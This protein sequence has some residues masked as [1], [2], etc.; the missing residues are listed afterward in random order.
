MGSASGSGLDEAFGKYD[1]DGSGM[2]TA[3]EF[4][5]ACEDIGFGELAN[6]LFME[7]DP[8]N[9][10]NISPATVLG[11][12]K[13]SR[14]I[15]RNAKR[16]I[17][18]LAF[19]GN[20]PDA[21]VDTSTWRLTGESKELLRAEMLKQMRDADPPARV[22][23]VFRAMLGYG[24]DAAEA[25]QM[26][27]EDFDAAMARIGLPPGNAW[28]VDAVFKQIDVNDDGSIGVPELR[29]W[30]NGVEM[31]KALAKS[32][33]L[34]S[35]PGGRE[36]QL[37]ELEWSPAVMREQI[38]LTLIANNLA[39]IDLLRAY[40]TAGDDTFAKRNMLGMCKEFVDDMVLWDDCHV[41]DVVVE[42]YG[43]LMESAKTAYSLLMATD[44]FDAARDK[45]RNDEK[46]R[47]RAQATADKIAANRGIPI[48]ELQKFLQS[49]WSDLKQEQ[50]G[51]GIACRRK[52]PPPVARPPPMLGD[53][54]WPNRVW[55][56][57][58]SSTAYAKGRLYRPPPDLKGKVPPP[59][60]PPLAPPGRHTASSGRHRHFI[61]TREALAV[62]EQTMLYRSH[63]APRL[64]HHYVQP[65]GKMQLANGSRR[66]AFGGASSTYVVSH[67]R[68]ALVTSLR[69]SMRSQILLA[70]QREG[71][72]KVA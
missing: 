53:P 46:K 65:G 39:P 28:L 25:T 2:L 17:T 56:A 29:S 72:V 52:P 45:A 9:N 64:V 1:N 48:S 63:S 7:F 55:P 40:A 57:R 66:V 35:R 5:R 15:S 60:I 18:D 6:E 59:P 27:R 12:I 16:V 61:T 71:G 3:L 58:G 32:I 26:Y 30:I 23:E 38:Q 10:G 68:A 51:S 8:E 43:I 24:R 37:A 62:W 13:S 20:R 11:M 34:R 49:G 14:G 19:D 41:R 67:Q 31:R 33:T 50:L 70:P 44:D 21:K 47:A 36:M 22:E 4:C 54:R 69:E 42:T